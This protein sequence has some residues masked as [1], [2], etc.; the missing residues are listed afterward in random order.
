MCAVDEVFNKTM[1]P[2][3][4]SSCT[5]VFGTNWYSLPG[6]KVTT[7]SKAVWDNSVRSTPELMSEPHRNVQFQL[8]KIAGGYY[9]SNRKH[10]FSLNGKNVFLQVLEILLFLGICKLNFL[11]CFIKSSLRAHTTARLSHPMK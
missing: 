10:Y 5:P 8:N 2:L 11:S 1:R 9:N 6:H 7:T 3:K 4:K